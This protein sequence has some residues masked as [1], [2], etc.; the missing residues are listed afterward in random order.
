[1]RTDQQARRAED[2]QHYNGGKVSRH[3]QTPKF[4][5]DVPVPD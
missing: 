3:G 2:R 5:Q 1:M 4:R